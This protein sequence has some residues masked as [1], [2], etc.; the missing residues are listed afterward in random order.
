M[1]YSVKVL[2]GYS[3][4]WSTYRDLKKTDGDFKKKN[5]KVTKFINIVIHGPIKK[6]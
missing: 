4:W 1:E 2:P 5:V 6:T 3:N